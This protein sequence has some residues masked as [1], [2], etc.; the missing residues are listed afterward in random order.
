MV[1]VDDRSAYDEAVAEVTAGR[2]VVVPT[3]TVYGLVA[4]VTDAAAVD[5]IFDLKARPD[6]KA[7]AVLVGSIDQAGLLAELDDR[8]RRLAAAFWPGALTVVAPRR[9]GL[10]LW[11]GGTGATVG[12]RCPASDFVLRL[13][14]QVGPLAATSA[15]RHG[16]PT[17]VTATAVAEQFAE[18]E[19]VVIDGGAC[20]GH[21]STVVDVTDTALAVIR[22][23]PVS[24]EAI[25]R[26]LA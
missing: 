12:L 20:R 18:A 5:R 17:P 1:A 10:S 19:L 13:A 14:A 26:I 9:P 16:R 15:N 8:F 21:P 3:D 4:L 6:D 2:P 22:D 25:A 11:L 24:T 23:G 7:M